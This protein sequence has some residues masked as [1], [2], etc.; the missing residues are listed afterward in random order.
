MI[1]NLQTS[2]LSLKLQGKNLLLHF[3]RSKVL[4]FCLCFAVQWAFA[5][6]SF[7]T[8][9]ISDIV[10]Q[11]TISGV[12]SDEDGNPLPGASVVVK[13]TTNGTQTD[14]DG[15]YTISALDDAT[16]VFSYVGFATQEI[17]V[18][19]QTTI[20]VTLVEDASK[21][22]E[23]VVVGYTTQTRG[24]L[25]GSVASVDLTEATKQPVVNV[26]EALEGRATGVTITNNGA[27]GGTPIVRIRGFG[28][29]NNNNPLY[30]IDGLQTTDSGILNNLNPNDIAQFNVLK[31]GAASIYGARASN[32]VIIITTK[33]GQYNQDKAT[34]TVDLSSGFSRATRLPD[35]LNAQQLGEVFFQSLNNDNIRNG[36]PNDPVIHPQF[37]PSPGITDIS[38]V[39]VPSTLLGAS[40]L[41]TGEAVTANVTPGGTNFLEEI[42]RNAPTQNFS[43]TLSNGSESSK[44]S[45]TLG[46]LNRQGIQL[47]TQFKRGQVRLNSEFKVNK[48]L[49][50]GEHLNTA[51]TQQ[52]FGNSVQ[53]AQRIS[54]LVPVRDSEGRFAGTYNNAIGL[55]NATNPVADLER[56]GDDFFKQ[57]RILGD[58]Y[59][60][61]TLPLDGLTFRTVIGGD[62]SIF[63]DRSFLA[64]NPEHSE[65]RGTNTLRE[66]NQQTYNWTWTNSLNY[67]KT[68]GK[69]T[70][71]ALL[72]IEAVESTG[73][74]TEVS[75]TGFLFETPDFY[76]LSNASG[77]PVVNPGNTFDFENTLS[78]VFGSVNYSYD[79]KYLLT[80]TLRRDRSSRFI[81][82]NQSDVFPAVSAGWVLSNEGFFPQDAV[83]NRLK[84]KV[85][86]GELGNQE[87]NS[88]NP[89]VNSFNLNNQLADFAFDG[90]SG[91]RSGAL[92]SQL[93]NPDITWETSQSFNAGAEFGLFD[94]ALTFGIEYFDITTDDLIAS[95]LLVNG[96]TGS[97]ASP[98][99]FNL[100]SIKNTGIDFS[101]SYANETS[102]GFSYGINLNISTFNNDVQELA[103]DFFQ[104]QGGFRGGEI[105]RTQVGQPLASFFG[106][107]ATGI[108][109]SAEEVAAG[110]D[111]GF[112]S[113][114]DGVGRLRYADLNGDNI[115]NDDDRD[116]IGNPHPDFTFGLN[117]NAA[118]K[119]WDISAFFAGT[120]G[121][122]IYNFDRIFTDFPTFFNGNRNARVLDSFDPVTN[123]N[124]S[125]PALSATLLNNETSPNSFFVED[126][127]FVRLKN[128]S[129]G[130]NFPSVLTDSWGI[131][132]LRLY[133]TATN[134]F[135]ITDYSGIDP[136]IQPTNGA[137][138]ALTLGVDQNTFP[139]SQLFT[140]GANLKL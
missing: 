87:V 19:G 7:D 74:S 117:L 70:V 49:T 66:R 115:I 127:S 81:G 122:D 130:Y 76:L 54:P 21:L 52:R 97:D 14:F 104:G 56:A 80:A 118:Y 34:I 112:A 114:E 42:F 2:L 53:I 111:Q 16:L 93:G 4:V 1:M 41:G 22:S 96:P 11:S 39:N 45:L 68:F 5:N 33:N 94:N 133:V 8:D 120:I 129:I 67:T 116:F 79:S 107:V 134:L 47:T 9:V 113:P 84:L 13:G 38:G 10:D 29:T 28:T 17:V 85:S 90:A 101:A 24:D 57:T 50:V 139:L 105:N 46:Y 69:H 71:N 95:N 65:A 128:L 63:N 92:L 108:Y 12:V 99:L 60:N 110:P 102:S 15:N 26:A 36:V 124:G 121:N 132:G 31:D 100:G 59:A 89:G 25:T 37:F 55:S 61:V 123:P 44:Y 27:P 43:T 138:S 140:I 58:V 137:N 131:D 78:S 64:L 106:R 32:G 77:A 73:K 109:R 20:N 75:A 62:I 6:P 126:G 98:P 72:A 91:V 88:G 18:N 125:A 136:E 83:V 103:G 82:D 3:V 86:Y 48:W 30:I 23:V 35:V 51:F 135:T 40:F 119:N